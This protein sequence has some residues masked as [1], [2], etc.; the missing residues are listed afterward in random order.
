MT[1]NPQPATEG[2]MTTNELFDDARMLERATWL[3]ENLAGVS[4]EHAALRDAIVDAMLDHLAKKYGV[5]TAT[6]TAGVRRVDEV[7]A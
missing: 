3:R 2:R 6:V 7:G 4:P 5:T 1:T